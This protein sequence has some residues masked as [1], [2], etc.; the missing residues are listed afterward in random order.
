[1]ESYGLVIEPKVISVN[2][3]ESMLRLGEHNIISRINNEKLIIDLRTV[4]EK[5]IHKI[6]SELEKYLD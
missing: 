5:D 1:M 6:S 2:K 4:F 3:L